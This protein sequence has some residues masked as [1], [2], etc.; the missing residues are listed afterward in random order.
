MPIYAPAKRINPT[1]QRIDSSRK[2]VYAGLL[3]TTMVDMFA[4]MVIFLL[5]NFSAEG[6]IIILPKG[7]QLP[8]AKNT[9]TLEISPSLIISKEKISFDNK[10]IFDT[11]T[12]IT[13]EN[14]HIPQLE[15][16]L[17]K[18]QEEKMKEILAK[19]LDPESLKVAEDELKRINIS[20]DKELPFQVVK[21][22]I[23]TAG[24][25]GFP[26]YRFAVF[27]KSN[28]AETKEEP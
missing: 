12:V 8:E 6:E 14:W 13:Q 2:G 5:M 16:V 4:I 28:K 24:F 10:D 23:Y 18:F 17:N 27:G 25:A 20:A 3:L 15:E 11:P 7:L 21:K 19:N 26:Q 1:I 22:V 9:G